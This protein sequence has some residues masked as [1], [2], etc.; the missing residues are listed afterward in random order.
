MNPSQIFKASIMLNHLLSLE[1]D[2]GFITH[3]VNT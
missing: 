1:G 3:C 2:I